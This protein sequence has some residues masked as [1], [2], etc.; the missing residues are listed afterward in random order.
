MSQSIQ[1]M[2]TLYKVLIIDDDPMVL[3][4]L[5]K[6]LQKYASQFEA[7]FASKGEDAI[8][9]LKNQPI[10][11][12]V[13][14]LVMPNV[15][16][17]DLFAYKDRY[18][19]RIQCIVM[20]S[21]GSRDF[22]KS[23]DND[24]AFHY[25]EKPVDCNVLAWAILG[26][27]DT[28]D[29]GGIFARVSVASLLQLV[30]IEAKTCHLKIKHTRKETG[31]F[32]FVNGVLWNADCGGMAGEDAALKMIGWEHVD[33]KFEK[34]SNNEVSR[35][36]DQELMHL[37]MKGTHLKDEN[38]KNG[39]KTDESAGNTQDQPGGES[40][41]RSEGDFQNQLD[42][43]LGDVFDAD[44]DDQPVRRPAEVVWAAWSAAC[45]VACLRST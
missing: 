12:M 8:E 7:V 42:D 23:A 13:T 34:L 45:S 22:K 43:V 31:S 21:H 1:G 5:E 9:I 10:S 27:I 15:G 35:K 30:E 40:R 19:P 25:I 2:K 14:D 20:T 6:G 11:V 24:D 29:E 17:L 44:S 18:Y 33:F 28:L 26:A 39:R 16:G 37:L 4:L 3:A 36:I 41:D 32:Y 38:K